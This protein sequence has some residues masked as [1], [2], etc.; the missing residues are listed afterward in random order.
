MVK[1][2]NDLDRYERERSWCSWRYRPECV[3]WMRK[4]QRI[5]LK[6]LFAL[7]RVF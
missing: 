2:W 5:S 7:Q 4:Q 6:F 1:E 3:T